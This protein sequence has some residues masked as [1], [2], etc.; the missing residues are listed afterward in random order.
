MNGG[1]ELR[2]GD[3]PASGQAYLLA[4]PKNTQRLRDH[5][6]RLQ[7]DHMTISADGLP[8]DWLLVC[9]HECATLSNDQRLLPDGEDGS[10][11]KPRAI[12]FVGGR[13][14][15]RGY[16]RMYLP[17]DLPA[18]ELDALDGTNVDC[19]A[20]LRLLDESPQCRQ[21]VQTGIH[22]KPHKRFRIELA[23]SNS[24]SYEIRAFR[25][26][27]I[28]G[29]AKLRIAGIGGELVDTGKPF[30]LDN[31]GRPV[32]SSEGLSGV[33]P[34]PALGESTTHLHD[35]QLFELSANKIGTLVSHAT[36]LPSARELFLDSLAQSGSIDYGVARD[37]IKRLLRDAGEQEDPPLVLL[38]LRSRG[39]LE[40]STTHKGHMSRIHAVEPTIFE[41][42]AASSGRRAYGVTGTLR[43]SHWDRIANE[44]SAWSSYRVPG[45]DKRFKS[46]RL[47]SD[48]NGLVQSTCARLEL[49]FS[50]DPAA[51]IAEWSSDIR[52]VR[53]ETFRNP[54]ESISRRTTH[55]N[56]VESETWIRAWTMSMF[57]PT[58]ESSPSRATLGGVFGLH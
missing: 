42:P 10:H 13:S 26:G 31:V 24:A 32:A 4:S 46:L 25:N 20:G 44:S 5:L 37:Q 34:P 2:E 29:Q 16:S 27:T 11:P 41:L 54:M 57:S 17:Y 19:S 38:D 6:L 12:R 3:L 45:G 1:I 36:H 51:A 7:P 48:E 18:I 47:L 35:D 28:L 23:S 56:F 8:A 40:I 50:S 21:D 53:D 58:T 14:V 55:A 22:F 9:I 43:L 52:S 49:R 30:S 15:R 39:H 33:L